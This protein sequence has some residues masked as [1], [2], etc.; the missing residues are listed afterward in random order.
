MPERKPAAFMSY[1]RNVDK[2]DDGYL[3]IL[4]ERLEGEIRVQSGKEFGIFQ[5]VR[6]IDWGE[7]WQERI[8]EALNEAVFLIPIITR[9][10]PGRTHAVSR[11]GKTPRSQGSD[12]AA[13]LH[14]SRRAEPSHA[15]PHRPSRQRDC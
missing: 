14:R 5:D 4:R 9:R 12:L 8:R 6:D 1:L 10:L 15:A 13:L 3:T 2:H 11:T 7:R